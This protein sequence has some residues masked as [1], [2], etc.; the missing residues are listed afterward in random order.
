MD[1]QIAIIGVCLTRQQRLKLRFGRLLLDLSEGCLSL[2]NDL[3]VFLNLT[4][5]N[6][7]D[8]IGNLAFHLVNVFDTIFQAH[9]LAH[10]LLRLL[11]ISPKVWIFGQGIEFFQSEFRLVVVKDAPSAVR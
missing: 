5:F 9:T 8:A 4:Q 1:F 6:Q 10:D 7:V 2:S 3:S 11:G